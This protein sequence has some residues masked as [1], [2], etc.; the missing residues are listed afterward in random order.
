MTSVEALFVLDPTHVKNTFMLGTRREVISNV[1]FTT[2]TVHSML[3]SCA[4]IRMPFALPR[5]QHLA[6]SSL[7]FIRRILILTVARQVIWLACHVGVS[8]T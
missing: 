1:A 8:T 5:P 7:S 3:K 6:C 4:I 2:A